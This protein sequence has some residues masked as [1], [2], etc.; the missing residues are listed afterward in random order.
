V[1]QVDGRWRCTQCGALIKLPSDATPYVVFKGKSGGPTMRTINV[2]DTEVHSCP[3]VDQPHDAKP[4]RT[5][6]N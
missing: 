5:P 4:Q 1:Q 6:S 2:D 3:A